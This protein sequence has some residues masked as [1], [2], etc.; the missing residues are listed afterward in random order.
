MTRAGGV[1]E[2]KTY[3]NFPVRLVAVAVLV[4]ISIYAVGAIILSG[5][6][7]LAAALY[8]FYCL[9]NEVHVMKMSCVDCYY[10]G[11]WCALGKGKAASFLFKRGDPGRFTARAI[12]WKELLPDMLVLMIPLVGGIALLIQGFSLSRLLMLAFLLALSLGG[13]YLVRSK[14][15][16]AY[17]KQRELGCPAEQFFSKQRS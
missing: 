1:E 17:C 5:Y 6:G 10:Y 8:L 11:K 13:N 9:G 15:A 2:I 12:S 4:N 7:N 16:C 14:I 3:E